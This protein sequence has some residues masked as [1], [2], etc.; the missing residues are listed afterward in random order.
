MPARPGPAPR[1]GVPLGPTPGFVL[2]SG[3]CGPPHRLLEQFQSQVSPESPEGGLGARLA[4]SSPAPRPAPDL[5]LGERP[6]AGR[7]LQFS[8]PALRARYREHPTRGA[9]TCRSARTGA[10]S[11]LWHPSHFEARDPCCTVP[12][13]SRD[14][15]LW[16]QGPGPRSPT[17]PP[18]KTS[19]PLPRVTGASSRADADKQELPD[20]TWR[21]STVLRVSGKE[22]LG[23]AGLWGVKHS[24]CTEGDPGEPPY[25]GFS[26]LTHA[27]VG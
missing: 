7:S 5:S 12:A 21:V 19:A 15:P 27:W 17:P 26:G 10:A 13:W 14:R 11:A 1:Y 4:L 22:V 2:Q 8:L 9:G 18:V 25:K 6:E 16:H 23:R 24:W 3:R 20:G